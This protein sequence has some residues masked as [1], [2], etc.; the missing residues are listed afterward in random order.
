[1]L[2]ISRTGTIWS[3]DVIEFHLFLLAKTPRL[4]PRHP[5][6]QYPT[7]GRGVEG[8][9]FEVVADS[10]TS[11]QKSHHTK[12]E[13]ASPPHTNNTQMSTLFQSKRPPHL[14]ETVTATVTSSP[15]QPCIS[16]LRPHESPALHSLTVGTV[17][18][19]THYRTLR[20]QGETA[21]RDRRVP[22]CL[23]ISCIYR[24]SND[25]PC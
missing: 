17:T 9:K 16:V 8:P 24:M 6:P 21:P 1:M 18:Y 23:A 7:C 15:P 3:R 19:S 20:L 10:I 5:S 12:S 4:A 13:L 2:N 14:L 11:C 25:W 22:H